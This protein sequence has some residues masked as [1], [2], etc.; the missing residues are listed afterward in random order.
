[1]QIELKSVEH[2]KRP[3]ERGY[4][5]ESRLSVFVKGENMLENLQNRTSR[6]SKFYRKEVLPVVL[7]H[8]GLTP[9]RVQWS[10]YAGCS[11]PCSPG[12]I[13]KGV[14]TRSDYYATISAEACQ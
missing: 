11:C 12:F 5:K 6:P 14:R 10:Q 8:F 1:M 7:K 3:W 9:D 2:G 4:N 13:L